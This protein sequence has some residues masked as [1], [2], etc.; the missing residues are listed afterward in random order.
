MK[1]LQC[2]CTIK[3][4]LQRSIAMICMACVIPTSLQAQIAQKSDD[5]S[6]NRNPNNYS[7]ATPN[8]ATFNKYMDSPVDLYSGTAQ[9]NIPVYTLKDGSVDLPISLSYATSG[10]KVNEEASWVGLGWMLDVGGC[11][12]RKVIG[13]IDCYNPEPYYKNVMAAYEQTGKLSN[14]THIKGPWSSDMRLAMDWFLTEPSMRK[15]HYEGRFNPDVFCYSCPDGK[16]RFVIDSRNDSIYLLDRREDVKIEM[17]TERSFSK[18]QVVD[19]LGSRLKG[20][21]VDFP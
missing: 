8:A 2:F 19:A 16:G 17:M 13:E 15:A 9:V 1:K 10:I 21:Q 12:T 14:T 5:Y 18:G 3:R 20:I 7:I 4:V 6:L 11:I